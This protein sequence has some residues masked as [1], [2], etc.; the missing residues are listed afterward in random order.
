MSEYNR[1]NV[2]L[3][4]AKHGLVIVGN[5]RTL[6]KDPIW[7][8]ILEIHQRNVVTGLHGAG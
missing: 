5:V 8:K 6:Q 2:A 3:T 7:K 1:I 4:R